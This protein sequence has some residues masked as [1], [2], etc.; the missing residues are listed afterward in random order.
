MS[1]L[2]F[3]IW[4]GQFHIVKLIIFYGQFDES[5]IFSLL[6]EVFQLEN[7]LEIVIGGDL[8]LISLLIDVGKMENFGAGFERCSDHTFNL[9]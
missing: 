3:I 7:G 5:T 6:L 9:C 1:F 8:N 2:F 4:L